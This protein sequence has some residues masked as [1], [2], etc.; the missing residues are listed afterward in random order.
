MDGDNGDKIMKFNRAISSGRHICFPCSDQ[1]RP[2][3]SDHP[4]PSYFAEP[5]V[6][7]YRT[8]SCFGA[9]PKH[10]PSDETQAYA[11]QR[12]VW[13]ALVGA[14]RPGAWKVGSPSRELPP[15]AA[16]VFPQRFAP[17]PACFPVGMFLGMGIEA[18]IAFRFGRDLPAHPLPYTREEILDAISSAHVAMELVD[19]RLADAET[20]GP[21]WRLADNLL[22]GGLVVGDEIPHWRELD[23]SSRRVRVLV[24]GTCTADTLGRPPLDDVFFC[25][26]WWIDHVGGA[27]AGDIV[28]TGA[29]NGAHNL[30]MPAEATVEFPGLG[31]ATVLLSRDQAGL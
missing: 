10:G 4:L 31:A 24:D 6:Q 11:V 25:L 26:P 18:E 13:H 1:T 23:F 2:M 30:A 9:R 29:W 14:G 28:T 22:N 7:A 8:S 19:T 20:A 5:L 16:P 27:R 15:L 3:A 21:L 12:E 17:S